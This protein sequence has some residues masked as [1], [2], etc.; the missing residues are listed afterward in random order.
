MASGGPAGGTTTSVDKALEICEVLSGSLTGQSVSEVGRRLRLPRP[1]VHR[2]LS[3]LKRRGFVRQDEDTSRYHL[4][5]KVLDLGFRLLGR[6]ELRL[7]AYPVLREYVL[8]TGA[9]SFIAVPPASEVT[10]VWAAG[11][12][13]VAIHT[14]YGKEMPAHCEMYFDP[15]QVTRRLSCL[16]LVKSDD[17][18]QSTGVI[19][20]LGSPAAAADARRLICTCAPV[21]DYTGREVARVGVF[22]HG[23]DERPILREYNRD[24]WEL[25]R[26]LSIRLGHLAAG[27]TGSAGTAAG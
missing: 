16:R 6:S 14:A 25:A 12:D 20:R 22:A 18:R 1:T 3:V 10:Y 11:P 17:V 8:R 19:R 26:L 2:L 9:R 4:T 23:S 24:A 21:H 7:H 13:E 27:A 5:L 15:T